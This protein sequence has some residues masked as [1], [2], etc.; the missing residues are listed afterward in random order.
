MP[1][2]PERRATRVPIVAYHSIADRHDH[3]V[4]Q[5]SLPVDAFERQLRF[6]ARH[7]FHTVTLHQVHDYLR[8]GTP[9]PPRS[10]ALTF[11]DGYL[12]NWVH[13]F[14]LLQKY[15]MKGTI[16]VVNEFVDPF[17]GCR[18]TLA[19]VWAGRI[20]RH[21]LSWWGH[22]SW[23][24]LRAMRASGLIDV[25]AHT[26]TH[27]W[28]F[29]SDRIVDFHHPADDYYWLEWNRHPERKPG[30]LTRDFREA[31]PWGTPVY[32]HAQT[33]LRPRYFE[34]PEVT[35]AAVAHVGHQG[36]RRFFERAGWREEL[37]AVVEA[38]RRERPG[39]GRVETDQEYEARVI[40]EMSASRQAI[41]REIGTPADFLCWPCGDYTPRLQQLAVER[42]GFRATVNVA[43]VTNRPGDDPSELRRIVFGQDYQGAGS[44]DLVFLNFAGNVSYHSGIACAFPVAPVA[45]RLMK[46]AR[47]LP[48]A[49][50][51]GKMSATP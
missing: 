39:G 22:A 33:M 14:P 38:L 51:R 18:P 36:G 26:R 34:D 15:G 25:Q 46:L 10:V 41:A 27:T 40:D 2:R 7:G 49:P 31:V 50:L 32:E 21:E 37:T 11:D 24:E 47:H 29:V 16:F 17:D 42:C 1:P 5:L 44:F 43:K 23:A 19:D 45:R 12:D 20:A 48:T 35:R 8:G 4:A 28:H 9:L 13:A 30:W 3:L 6:L